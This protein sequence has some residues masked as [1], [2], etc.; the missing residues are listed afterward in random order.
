M[1]TPTT[2]TETAITFDAK[3]NRRKSRSNSGG[4]GKKDPDRARLCGLFYLVVDESRFTRST[5]KDAL[6]GIGIRNIVEMENAEEVLRYLAAQHLVDVIVT[7]F[8][9][10][11]MSGAEFV[12]WLRR[13]E[14]E[15]ARRIPVVM[16]SDHADEV[17]IRA[18]INA[19]V[20]EYL[21]KPFS[22]KDLYSRLHRAVFSPKPFVVGPGYIGPDR[23]ISDDKPRQGIERR[24]ALSPADLLDAPAGPEARRTETAQPAASPKPSFSVLSETD[25][26]GKL[27]ARIG[28]KGGAG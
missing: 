6:H 19:G 14:D 25:P 21:P 4:A 8:E 18:A 16:V 2:P 3:K 27:K 24:C 10:P 22:Q 9:M 7:D 26:S 11:G 17:H 15:R 13:S 20:N 23:R 12:W 28:D 5:I 1:A